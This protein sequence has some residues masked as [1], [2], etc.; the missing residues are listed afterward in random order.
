MANTDSEY[1]IS[2]RNV[3]KRFKTKVFGGHIHALKGVSLDVKPGTIFGLLGPNGAGKT[4]LVKILLG[5]I[6]HSDGEAKLLG[7]KPGDK[8]SRRKVGYLPEQLKLPPHQTALTALE[9]YGRLSGMSHSEIRARRGEVIDLVE[10][11]GRDKESVKRFSKGMQQRLGLAQA[12]LHNP[13]VLFLD[14]PTDGLDPVG[15]S[16]VRTIMKRL[17]EQGRTVFVN[18]HLLQEVELVCD[19]VAILDKGSLKYVGVLDA[20]TPSDDTTIVVRLTG[21]AEDMETAATHIDGAVV[22]TSQT[23]SVLTAPS[24]SQSD[25]DRIV[26]TLRQNNLGIVQLIRQ[27]RTLEDAFLDLISQGEALEAELV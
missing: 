13:E 27:R 8:R 16:Q 10:L 20:L 5:I 17:K 25:T 9:Y 21:K 7:L 12:L 4:T 3:S 26:D 19:E 14:E 1:V 23:G 2:V 11:T 24:S 6:R 15:R 22:T 18:S